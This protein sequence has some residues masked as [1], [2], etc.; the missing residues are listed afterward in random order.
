MTEASGAVH[1]FNATYLESY[2]GVAPNGFVRLT[3]ED[4]EGLR[5]QGTCPR[6]HGDTASE[7]RYGVPGTGTKGLF[8]ALRRTPVA[9]TQDDTHSL[10]LR[11]VHFCEC[12][13]PHPDLPADAPFVGCGAS[14]RVGQLSNRDVG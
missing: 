5:V 14:W 7:Y 2:L 8:S 4:G 6:C 3:A 12:G 13:H 10:I 1:D 9:P 11:E